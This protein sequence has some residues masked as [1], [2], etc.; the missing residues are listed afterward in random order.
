MTR[1]ADLRTK[2]SKN[3]D[4]EVN[5]LKTI[6]SLA[7]TRNRKT[8]VAGEYQTWKEAVGEESQRKTGPRLCRTL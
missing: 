2:S 3:R 8:P 1:K 4:E 7:S 6:M 5:R